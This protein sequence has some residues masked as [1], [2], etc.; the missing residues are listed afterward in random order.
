MELWE[1][2]L[3]K[4]LLW[5]KRPKVGRHLK[6]DRRNNRLLVHLRDKF[7]CL[8]FITIWQSCNKYIKYRMTNLYIM[9]EEQNFD[10]FLLVTFV[11]MP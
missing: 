5:N 6:G 1:Q 7:K 11:E 10:Y 3:E 4:H 9:Q 2:T 8:Q